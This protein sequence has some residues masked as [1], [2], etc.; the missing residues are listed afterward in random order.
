MAKS[1][2]SK[3]M[4]ESEE[5]KPNQNIY[6]WMKKK[7]NFEIDKFNKLKN[8]LHKSI[9]NNELELSNKKQNLVI[10]ENQL[11]ELQSLLKQT[12]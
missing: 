4:D 8:K 12:I 5:V 2:K 9:E 11:I 7:I 3:Q 10:I 1:K 6:E